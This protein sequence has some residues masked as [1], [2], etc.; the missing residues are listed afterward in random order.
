MSLYGTKKNLSFL[1]LRGLLIIETKF[2]DV[3]IVVGY[4]LLALH[5]DGKANYGHPGMIEQ[6]LL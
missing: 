3:L 2:H 6:C 4:G 5:L 1:L